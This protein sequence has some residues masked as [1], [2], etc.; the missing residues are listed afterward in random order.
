MKNFR[1]NNEE[2]Y[3]YTADIIIKWTE[4]EDEIKNAP[5]LNNNAHFHITSTQ[6]H[7]KQRNEEITNSPNKSCL[8]YY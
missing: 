6:I 2:Y 8:Y 7:A 3:E 5:L 4:I 1:R